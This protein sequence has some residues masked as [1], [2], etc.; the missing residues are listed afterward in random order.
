M[1]I[2][3]FVLILAAALSTL[4]CGPRNKDKL[5]DNELAGAEGDASVGGAEDTRCTALTTHDEIKRQLFARAAEIRGS[6][7]DNY[8]RIAG[9]ALIQI[10]GGAPVSANAA[11]A[12]VDCRGQATLRLPNG[13]KVA[14]GRTTLG[15]DIGYSVGAGPR[16]TVTLGQSDSIA[17]PLATLTQNRASASAAAPSP[18]PVDFPS[19]SAA[20]EPVPEPA[21]VPVERP[22]PSALPPETSSNS[23]RPSFD[24]RRGRTSGERAV[25]DSPSLAALDRE[26]AAQYRSAAANGGPGERRLLA[27]TRDRFL[28]YRDRCNNDACIANTYRGRMREIDDI[29]AGR[30][31]GER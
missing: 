20:R 28:T 9:Y 13:L 31:R 11:G 17:I 23:A 1:R 24:C 29:A 26:M 14:G 19:Q 12:L 8:Q 22:R 4:A 27:Q 7:G 30:W 10:D 2:S 3:S 25:C 15:G 21:T 16:G 5:E 18:A 6:N